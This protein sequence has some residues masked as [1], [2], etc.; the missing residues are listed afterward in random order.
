M[1]LFWRLHSLT[2]DGDLANTGLTSVLAHLTL[3]ITSLQIFFSPLVPKRSSLKYWP[4]C[5]FISWIEDSDAES[6]A[7]RPWSTLSVRLT[8][9]SSLSQLL[10]VCCIV[11]CH[12]LLCAFCVCKAL[13]VWCSCHVAHVCLHESVWSLRVN[14]GWTVVTLKSELGIFQNMFGRNKILHLKAISAQY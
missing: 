4:Q 11:R 8:A 7:A 14:S 3:C 12:I 10:I 9:S 13:C 6:A 1:L 2:P 5:C